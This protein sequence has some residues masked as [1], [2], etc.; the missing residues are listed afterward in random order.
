MPQTAGPSILRLYTLG[1]T[2]VYVGG[3]IRHGP[4]LPSR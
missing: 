4:R 3:G 2:Q 1:P